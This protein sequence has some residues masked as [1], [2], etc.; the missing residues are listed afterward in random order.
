M[1]IRLINASEVRSLLTMDR[2]I[3]AM[4][5]AMRALS[6]GAVTVP[7]RTVM[8][9]PDG[10][11]QVF[12]MPGSTTGFPVYGT[13]VVSQHPG[14]AAKNLPTIQGFVV[15]FDQATGSPV[16]MIDGAEITA[17]RTAAASALAT[18]ILARADAAS[19]GVFGTGVLARSH[20]DA[21]ARVRKVEMVAIWG[22]DSAGAQALAED[23]SRRTGCE[24]M[25]AAYPEDAA[26][27]D[28]VTTVTSAGRPVLKGRWLRPGAH[29]NL[30]GAHSPDRREADSDVIQGASI[31]VDMVASARS[32]AGDLLIPMAEGRF[33][34]SDIRAEI[35]QVLL[36]SA[37]GRGD[38]QEITLYKSLGVVAQDLFAAEQ[39]YR[40]A[41][42]AGMGQSVEFS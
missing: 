18:K 25:A 2:C 14:N 15:L 38:E 22:R 32:E 16:A 19:H 27:C 3:E 36:G 30:V 6:G 33:R 34:E 11:G 21:I 31:Y 13:K 17:I 39:V 4:D 20:L 5:R 28:I 8:N 1:A 35:G 12:L 29:V 7:P 23:Y 37:P 26:A 42:Q 9:L 24:T 41:E 10:A 40:D